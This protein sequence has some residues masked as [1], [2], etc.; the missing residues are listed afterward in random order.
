[1]GTGPPYYPYYVTLAEK[2]IRAKDVMGS[3]Y[4]VNSVAFLR[5]QN[6]TMQKLVTVFLMHIRNG[7]LYYRRP[8][9]S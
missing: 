4:I 5:D 2:E 3:P 1:M 8:T 9:N 6:T 7:K